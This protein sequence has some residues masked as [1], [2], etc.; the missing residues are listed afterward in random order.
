MAVNFGAMWSDAEGA[1]QVTIFGGISDSANKSEHCDIT[2]FGDC[3][4]T[5]LNDGGWVYLHANESNGRTPCTSDEAGK[6]EIPSHT[7]SVGI[8]I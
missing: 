7:Q 1:A 6:P 5:G 2:T 4:A 8:H 3:C